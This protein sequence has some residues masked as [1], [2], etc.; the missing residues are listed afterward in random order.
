M[1]ANSHDSRAESVGI[2]R[3][4]TES[5]ENIH[6]RHHFIVL[7]FSPIIHVGVNF[8]I[9][10]GSVVEI[11]GIITTANIRVPSKFVIFRKFDTYR[12]LLMSKVAVLG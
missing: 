8:L 11:N 12:A 4:D 9:E 6:Y 2:L 5:L 1:V 10:I 7:R 3:L